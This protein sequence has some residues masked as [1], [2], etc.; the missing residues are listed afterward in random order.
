MKPEPLKN[1][2][3]YVDSWEFRDKKDTHPAHTTK[4]FEEED[5]KSAVEWY[6][7]EQNK[8]LSN[9]PLYTKWVRS[10]SKLN[11][12]TWTVLKAFEDVIKGEK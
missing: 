12:Y 9:N 7:I 5:L 2:E 8:P 11:Y 3:G 10:K 4:V 1:K 6:L